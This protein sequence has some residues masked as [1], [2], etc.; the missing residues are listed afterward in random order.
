MYEKQGK[1]QNKD[2]FY[3][4][5]DD[6]EDVVKRVKIAPVSKLWSGEKE[7]SQEKG[8][9]D[10]CEF[11]TFEMAL[12]K[13]E[14]GYDDHY[15]QFLGNFEKAKNIVSKITTTRLGGTKRDVAGF[16]P[17]VPNAL[18]GLPESMINSSRTKRKRIK[19]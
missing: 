12:N 16:I 10:F 3:S 8:R 1:F 6:I 4:Y 5:Y 14:F 7:A 18:L 15:K 19:I 11:P 17:I 9:K 13:L 2:V